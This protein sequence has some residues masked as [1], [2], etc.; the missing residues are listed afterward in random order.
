MDSALEPRVLQARHTVP[1]SIPEDYQEKIQQRL[2]LMLA[3]ELIKALADNPAG[4]IVS[5]VHEDS[6][7]QDDWMGAPVRT[8][9]TWLHVVRFPDPETYLLRG[10]PYDG[11]EM[12]FTGAPVLYLPA[13]IIFPSVLS[14][15]VGDVVAEA[16]AFKQLEYERQSGTNVY[17]FRR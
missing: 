10:G 1:V 16:V 2:R 12:K 11:R 4:L 9:T 14:E 7:D 8:L 3:E 13:P 5:S 17:F 6:Y 15:P